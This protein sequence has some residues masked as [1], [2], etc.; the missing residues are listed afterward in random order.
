[1]VSYVQDHG[2]YHGSGSY[3]NA[4]YWNNFTVD[5]PDIKCMWFDSIEEALASKKLRKGDIIYFEPRNWSE[6]DSYGN[7]PDCHIGFYWGADYSGEDKFWHSAHGSDSKGHPMDNA[8]TDG[9][10][11]TRLAPKCE[12]SICVIPLSDDVPY[13]GEIEIRKN[14]G[15]PQGDATAHLPRQARALPSCRSPQCQISPHQNRVPAYVA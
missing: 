6:P 15:K 9:N 3:I 7:Y 2:G 12:S 5:N 13:Y 1:M 14:E 10:Q 8:I 4:S 11:M